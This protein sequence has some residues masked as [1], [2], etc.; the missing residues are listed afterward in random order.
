MATPF[1]EKDY[2]RVW[3]L[4]SFPSLVIAG[5]AIINYQYAVD[6][7]THEM[8]FSSSDSECDESETLR[9]VPDPGASILTAEKYMQLLLQLTSST[10]VQLSAADVLQLSS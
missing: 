7:K 5:E 4:V 1:A 3:W 9:A 6:Y 10:A 2:G 8:R